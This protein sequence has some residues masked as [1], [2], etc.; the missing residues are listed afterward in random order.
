M[1]GAALQERRHERVELLR[2]VLE[3]AQR[4]EG[5]EQV[6]REDGQAEDRRA[7]V[8]GS[9]DG[10]ANRLHALGRSKRCAATSQLPTPG[11]SPVARGAPAVRRDDRE[12][13]T[14]SK[15]RFAEAARAGSGSRLALELGE[16]LV[17]A[18]LFEADARRHAAAEAE[19]LDEVDA[20]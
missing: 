18:R 15:R 14:V 13:P 7:R 17:E 11:P 5:V 12:Y 6:E 20:R 3:V 9:A 2:P 19:E 16:N 4:G 1:A 10:A 8:D